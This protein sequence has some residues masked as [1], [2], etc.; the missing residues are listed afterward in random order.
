[1]NVESPLKDKRVLI[2]DDEPDILDSV[3]EILDMCVVDKAE[4]YDTAVDSL[5]KK[6]Y[7]VVILDIMGVNGFE[8][9]KISDSRG[10]PTVMLTAHAATPEALKKSIQLGAVSFLPKDH[11]TEL[12]ELLED[13]VRGGGKRLWWM[14]SYD[15]LSG[16]FDDR[17]G[18]DWKEK[19][20]FF[21]EFEKSLKEQA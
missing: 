9:L 4:D 20:N 11:I 16:Y 1:M 15:Q 19:D 21:K 18:A 13:V 2:V 8:L 17:F 7:D 10:F 6:T 14:K 5:S 12:T 3:G